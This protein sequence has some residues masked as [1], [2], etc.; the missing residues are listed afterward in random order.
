MYSETP[1]ADSSSEVA[2]GINILK[3][4]SDPPL[5]ADDEYPAWVSQLAEPQ[6]TFTELK[7][8]VAA[9]PDQALTLEEVRPIGFSSSS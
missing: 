1:F 5:K 4:G 2:T 9:R 8:T 6:L 7:R 3:G